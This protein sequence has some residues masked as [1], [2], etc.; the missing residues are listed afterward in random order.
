MEEGFVLKKRRIY[1]FCAVLTLLVLFLSVLIFFMN[2]QDRENE[3]EKVYDNINRMYGGSICIKLAED[4]SYLRVDTNPNDEPEYY[5]EKNICLLEDVCSML[6]FPDTVFAELTASGA[7]DGRRVYKY[8]GVT[9]TWRSDINF[10]IEALFT[11][12]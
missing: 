10:G 6:G 3:L 9:V 11:M 2:F 1:F 7:S 12:V 5:N 4:K 8:N